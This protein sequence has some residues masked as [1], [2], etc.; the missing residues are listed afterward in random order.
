M[1]K[2]TKRLTIAEV[3]EDILKHTSPS[4]KAKNKPNKK[5]A[6]HPFP[7]VLP[8]S[9][10][11]FI[12]EAE[13]SLGIPKDFLQAGIIYAASVAIGA[14]RAAVVNSGDKHMANLFMVL[15]GS[16]NS[17]KSAGLKLPLK[18]LR[19]RQ[20]DTYAKYQE[21]KAEY[22][23]LLMMSKK[24]RAQQE[25]TSDLPPKPTWEQ[26]LTT[27]TTP[28]ALASVLASNLHG[29]GVHRDE[30]AGW[31]K[32]FDRYAPG[33]EQE[34]WLQM[35]SVISLTINRKGS[36]PINISRP[37]VPVA[38]GIQPAILEEIAKNGRGSNGF[39][40][41]FLYVWPDGLDKPLWQDR[42]MPES[43]M[44]E[45]AAG[46]NKLLEKDFAVGN[47]PHLLT[48]AKEAKGKLLSFF[49]ETNK[50]LCDEA[51]NDLLKG[52]HGKYDL[53]TIR[54]A[55]ILQM[56][57]HAYE[58]STEEHIELDTV[59]RAIRL[60]EYFRGN[61]L[62]VFERLNNSTPL[63]LLPRDRQ[64]IYDELPDIKEGFET[65]DGVLI[66]GKNGMPERTFKRWLSTASK[67]SS[68]LFEKLD[69]GKYLKIY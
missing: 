2:D 4:S 8:P 46:I 30:L 45:Y 14:S 47:S 10:S 56:L 63:D 21:A 1:T 15:I 29:V 37:Y 34:Q 28:E 32:S 5:A 55:L 61:A 20:T 11:L 57:W 22:D 12:D 38:G 66:A 6:L 53:H 3:G 16:P 49:N 7:D 25:G 36:E 23:A 18:P 35:W 24:E 69:R 51:P 65:K 26:F 67:G 40:D 60:A 58:G 31:F 9:L 41:R 59:K 50:R 44:D 19:Q 64:K 43:L 48:F 62:K 27:D 42:D 17:N 33:G 13:A 52:L 39:F 68:Q 54:L